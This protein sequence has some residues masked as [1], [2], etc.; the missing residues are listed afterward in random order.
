MLDELYQEMI[1]DHNNN[2]R[3]H[4][5]LVKY[6]HKGVGHNPLCGDDITIY[7]DIK[8]NI[9]QKIGY[10]ACGCAISVASASIMSESIKGI[11]ASKA[12]ELKESVHEMLTKELHTKGLGK[13]EILKG[14]TKFPAR[15]KC[16]SLCWHT[17]EAAFNKTVATTE[18]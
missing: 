18:D 15:V 7:L 3:N 12:L 8:D 4:N 2:P 17:L 9:V 10:K 5:E 1:L 14:V 6:T 13:I 16:A 11:K